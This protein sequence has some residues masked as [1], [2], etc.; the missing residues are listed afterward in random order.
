MIF[1]S[2]DVRR[3]LFLDDDRRAFGSGI[4]EMRRH[5]LWHADATVRGGKGRNISLV[6]CVTAVEMH[7]IG[8][9]CAIKVCSARFTVFAY[10][11]VRLHNVA[12]IIDVIAELARDVIPVFRDNMVMA[13][14]RSESAFAGRH[15]RFTDKMFSLDRS[16]LSARSD[17]PRYGVF[18]AHH[19]RSNN[20]SAASVPLRAHC[21]CRG[22]LRRLHFLAACEKEKDRRASQNLN[23]SN[24]YH[25]AA[26]TNV[27]WAE[28]NRNNEICWS[29]PDL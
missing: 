1:S 10:V 15:R 11:D 26:K 22:L 14:W 9:A 8:H 13:R 23:R 29:A 24:A 16:K 18:Q 28:C 12:A 5:S 25:R 2:K 4:E 7:A 19:L 27:G 6:H 3:R 21:V 17:A 20:Q